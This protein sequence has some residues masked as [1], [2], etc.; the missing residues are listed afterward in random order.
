MSDPFHPKVPLDFIRRVFLVMA[1]TPRH[2]YQVLT[3]RSHRLANLAP[4]L[5]WPD[6]VWMGVSIENDRY[7]FRIDHLR[8]VP[9][10]IRFISAEPLLGPLPDLDLSGIHWL[11]VGGESGPRA[12]PMKESWALDLRDQCAAADVPFFFKQW[13]GP[14][15]RRHRKLDGVL[16]QTRVWRVGGLSGEG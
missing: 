4:E 10:A 3:K 11:I 7:T 9:A 1:D 5:E 15:P 13:G 16:H 14:T 8:T 2:T 6:N 12:R